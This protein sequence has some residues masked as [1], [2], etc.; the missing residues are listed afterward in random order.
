MKYWRCSIPIWK[1]KYSSKSSEESFASSACSSPCSM[2][3]FSRRFFS[4][5]N[6]ERFW[7]TTT[8][9]K[10][11]TN[12]TESMRKKSV[13]PILTSMLSILEMVNIACTLSY[14]D[15]WGWFMRK[16]SYWKSSQSKMFSVRYLSSQVYLA[17]SPQSQEISQSWCICQTK[18]SLEP[19]KTN[20]CIHSK[21]SRS[22]KKSFLKLNKTSLSI[23]T[24]IYS[25][26]ATYVKQ[27]VTLQLNANSFRRSKSSKSIPKKFHH[28]VI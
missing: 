15:K 25:S 13:S 11:A 18:N 5:S 24:N 6:K 12:A 28:W 8:F 3:D 7:W 23:A 1:T 21:S 9:L 10:R 2:T 16:T 26:I 22:A 17:L 4:C 27:E 14:K 19:L 20:L